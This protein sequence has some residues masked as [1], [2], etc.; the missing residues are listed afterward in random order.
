MQPIPD[1]VSID[2]HSLTWVNIIK[3]AV[4]RKE[5]AIARLC[6]PHCD[7]RQGDILRGEIGVLDWL[8]NLPQ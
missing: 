4:L 1:K 3:A 2:I 8:V 6:S 5:Y 7:P